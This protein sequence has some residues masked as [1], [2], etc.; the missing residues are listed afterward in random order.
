M[1]YDHGRTHTNMSDLM[2]VLTFIKDIKR[3]TNE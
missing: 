3:N 2:L 1:I